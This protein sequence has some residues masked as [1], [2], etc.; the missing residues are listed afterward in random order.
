MEIVQERLRIT[1]E[2]LTIA[3]LFTILVYLSY[4]FSSAQFQ[5]SNYTVEFHQTVPAT[6]DA[7]YAN[8]TTL[9]TNRTDHTGQ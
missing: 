4:D 6:D 3:A 9:P 2:L 7:T 5:Q 8:G 1:F